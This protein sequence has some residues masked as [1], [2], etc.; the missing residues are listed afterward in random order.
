MA[1][2]GSIGFAIMIPIMA[3]AA[4]LLPWARGALRDKGAHSGPRVRQQVPT[5]ASSE[6][7]ELTL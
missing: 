2:F 5:D 1:D 3:R 4:P 7:N 6:I